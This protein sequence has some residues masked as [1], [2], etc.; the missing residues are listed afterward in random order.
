MRIFMRL[1]ALRAS[2]RVPVRVSFTRTRF[3]PPRRTR[4][5]AVPILRLPLKTSMTA[6]PLGAAD[7]NLTRIVKRRWRT[8]GRPHT[9]M[10]ARGPAGARE[11]GVAGLRAPRRGGGRQRAR[12][13]RRG[14]GRRRRTRRRRGRWRGRR[15]D[16]EREVGGRRVA[17]RLARLEAHHPLACRE[18][19]RGA[20]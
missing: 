2:S 7:A 20:P 14:G 5:R 13:D 17:A 18:R 10:V 3:A 11:G 6:T 4:V 19:C 12:R 16:V 8:F 1:W 9:R 15:G